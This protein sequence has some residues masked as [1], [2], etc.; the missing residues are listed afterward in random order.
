MDL[1]WSVCHD[2]WSGRV[3]FRE[4][5]DGKVAIDRGQGHSEIV[6][7]AAF[8]NVDGLAFVVAAI[9]SLDAEQT[10]LL[11]LRLETV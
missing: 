8:S 5:Q 1:G 4:S 6:V 11:D 9:N 2:A 3:D 7:S 10:T